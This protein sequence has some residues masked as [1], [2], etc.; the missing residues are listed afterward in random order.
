MLITVE[1][2]MPT[3][4]SDEEKSLIIDLKNLNEKVA[5]Q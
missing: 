1:L 5:T 2:K 4:I 3:Q